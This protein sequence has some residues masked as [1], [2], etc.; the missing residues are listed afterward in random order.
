VRRGR[1][2]ASQASSAHA[3]AYSSDLPGF[4]RRWFRELFSLLPRGAVLVSLKYLKL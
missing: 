3:K 1:Q 2:A 4:A